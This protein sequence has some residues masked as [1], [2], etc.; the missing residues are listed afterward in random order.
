MRI[1]RTPVVLLAAA[2]LTSLAYLVLRTLIRRRAIAAFKK[3]T[4]ALEPRQIDEP[5]GLFNYTEMTRLRSSARR[6][7]LTTLV[8]RRFERL[9]HTWQSPLAIFTID[10]DNLRVLLGNLDD[11]RV[12]SRKDGWAPLLSKGI[13]VTDGKEWAHSRVGLCFLLTP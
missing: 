7:E 11:W 13:F 3:R 9:G 1:A 12:G 8:R 5:V 10:V 4:G 2:G 6:G